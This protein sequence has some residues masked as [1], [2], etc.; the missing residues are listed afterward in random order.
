MYLYPE[1]SNL[2]GPAVSLLLGVLL[3]LCLLANVTSIFGQKSRLILTTCAVTSWILIVSL[4]VKMAVETITIKQF[5]EI[6]K[7]VAYHYY[8]IEL[9][10]LIFL[11]L[12]WVTVLVL[13]V[14]YK[15][16]QKRK[17]KV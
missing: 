16:G 7:H 17:S 10:V 14:Y 12:A 15:A 3:P 13:A 9:L 11:E 1:T 6:D 2:V 8:G 5:L 4:F